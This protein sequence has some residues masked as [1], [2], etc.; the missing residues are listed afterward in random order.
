MSS[1][2]PRPLTPAQARG[3]LANRLGRVVDRARQIDVRIG[4]RPYQVFL[5]WTKWEGAARGDGNQV[6]VCRHQLV[7]TPVVSDLTAMQ[8]KP[9]SAGVALDGNLRITEISTTYTMD[10]LQGWTIPEKGEDQVPQPLDFFWEVV[11]DG[12][13]CDPTERKRFRVSS[14]PFLDVPNQQWVVMLQKMGGDMGRDGQPQNV[15]PQEKVDRWKSRVA[16]APP[17]DDSDI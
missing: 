1:D 6:V 11:E 13:H 8:K 10:V 4:N 14:A 16:K 5:V 2:R 15:T 12:R 17:D 3:S 9:L 7:P